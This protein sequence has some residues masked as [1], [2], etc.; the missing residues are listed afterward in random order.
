MSYKHY[1]FNPS[2][3]SGQTGLSEVYDYNTSVTL[4]STPDTGSTFIGWSGDCSSC[5]LNN[6]CQLTMNEDK[7][8]VAVFN[9]IESDGGYEDVVTGVSDDVINNAVSADIV[10]DAGIDIIDY[11]SADDVSV[12]DI[13]ATDVRED[14]TILDG[15]IKDT[16]KDAV[17]DA[18]IRIDAAKGDNGEAEGEVSEDF[19]CSLIE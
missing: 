6:V 16:G 9:I 13:I 19:S 5:Q 14:T 2:K 7:T 1:K 18:V 8:C 10:A 4:T 17:S 11:V 3:M 15:G 12:E